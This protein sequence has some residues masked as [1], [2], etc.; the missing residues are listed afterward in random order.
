MPS[1]AVPTQAPCPC[2]GSE[3]TLAR[4]IVLREWSTDGSISPVIAALAARGTHFEPHSGQERRSLYW[5]CNDCLQTGRALRTDPNKQ[6]WFDCEPYLAY[7][8]EARM[9]VDCGGAF[10]FAKEEQQH[11]YETLNFWVWSRPIRCSVCNARRK[12]RIT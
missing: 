5:A 1:A 7:Y 4:Q 6:K 12:G 10:V 11:W 8:D 9:C 2:C 3:V